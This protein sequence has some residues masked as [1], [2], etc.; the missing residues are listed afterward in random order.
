VL[1]RIRSDKRYRD[2]PVIFLTAKAGEIHEI[3]G[4]ELGA[5][6]YIQK[7]ISPKK[8]IARVKANLKKSDSLVKKRKIPENISYGPIEIDRK[9]FSV[10]VDGE[11]VYFP[12]K[13]FELL[14]FLLSNPGRVFN[15]EMLL[16]EVWG[17]DIY[18]IERTVDVHM[19]KIREKLGKYS[20]LIETIKGVGYK[21]KSVE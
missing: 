8:L 5:S 2:I 16:K 15:R 3:K 13:E 9:S 19:R 20:D 21:V 4:L 10:L 7:P 1:E 12:R 6:D 18:V 17:N 14:F 11:T